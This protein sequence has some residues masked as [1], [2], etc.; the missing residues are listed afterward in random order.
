M[1]TSSDPSRTA[2][3]SPYEPDA[4]HAR[5]AKLVGKWRGGSKTIM[6]PD[7]PAV[8]G[9]WEGEVTALLGGRFVRFGY[10][11][12]VGD[13][14][15]TGELTVAYESA[16]KVWRMSWI[17]SFHTGT[18]ILGMAS[19]PGRDGDSEIGARGTWFAAEGHP[20]WGWRTVIDDAQPGAMILRMYVATPEGEE[21]L[22]VEVLLERVR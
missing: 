14:P 6:G 2:H 12:M 3:W 11:G 15:H 13:K 10:R 5:L 22:G 1:T 7:A 18:A 4:A 9:P 21:A 8:E 20:H 19:E 17:D 16:E